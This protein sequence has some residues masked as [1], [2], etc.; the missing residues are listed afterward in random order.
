MKAVCIKRVIDRNENGLMM[1]EEGDIVNYEVKNKK[2]IVNNL[3]L[4][5]VAFFAHFRVHDGIDRMSYSD[6]EYILCNHI[7]GAAVLFPNSYSGIRHL[8]IQD[9]NHDTIMITINKDENVI[10]VSFS[11]VQNV[12]TTYEDALDGICAHR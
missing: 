6:F 9:W 4:T 3:T 1:I 10:R 12:Y 2:F 7:F 11:D 5:S 8:I